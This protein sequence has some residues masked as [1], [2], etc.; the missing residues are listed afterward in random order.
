MLN[1]IFYSGWYKEEV[2]ENA[3]SIYTIGVNFAEGIF[4]HLASTCFY[5]VRNKHLDVFTNY[6]KI[7]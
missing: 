4:M 2:K 1:Q 5:Y 6:V 7:L 3:W